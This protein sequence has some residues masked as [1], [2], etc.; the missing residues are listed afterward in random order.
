MRRV[1][2]H[3][4][5]AAVARLRENLSPG[6]TVYTILR[7]VSSSGMSRRLDVYTIEPDGDRI[8]FY[9]L[10][11]WVADACEFGWN[12]DRDQLVVGGCGMDMGFHVIYTLSSILWPDGFP[13]AGEKRC[14]SNDHFNGM[15]KYG[16]GIHHRDGGYALK[17]RWI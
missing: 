9:W 8:R 1:P 11:K 15:R 4:Q 3:D 17:Q 12:K 5:D 2:Q 14:E 6:D 13:C 16:E 10:T 7:N